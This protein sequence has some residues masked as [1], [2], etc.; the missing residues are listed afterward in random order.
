MLIAEIQ[1]NLWERVRVSLD[2]FK[3]HKVCNIRVFFESEPGVWLP[4]TKGIAFADTLLPQILA[5]L[6]SAEEQHKEAK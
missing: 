2:D 4:S 3:G 6:K 5:A 1:K